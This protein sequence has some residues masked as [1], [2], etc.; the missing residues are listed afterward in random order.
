LGIVL[1]K[2]SSM[3]HG[4]RVW[5]RGVTHSKELQECKGPDIET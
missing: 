1:W 4:I 2:N 5:Q 3:R